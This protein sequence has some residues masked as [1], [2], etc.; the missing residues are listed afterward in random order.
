V[1]NALPEQLAYV[2]ALDRAVQQP[3]ARAVLG[4]DPESAGYRQDRTRTRAG[5]SAI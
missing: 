5:G 1:I 3:D 2:V 4:T